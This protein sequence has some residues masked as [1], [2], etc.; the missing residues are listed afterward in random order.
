MSSATSKAGLAIRLR[1]LADQ[2]ETIGAD[3][4]YYGGMAPWAGCGRMLVEYTEEIITPLAYVIEK[5]AA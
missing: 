3:V 1:L 4:D 2:M 5:D